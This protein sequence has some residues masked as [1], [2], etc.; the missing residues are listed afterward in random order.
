MCNTVSVENKTKLT[1]EEQIMLAKK[2]G[3]LP[4]KMTIRS[5]QEKEEMKKK[6]AALYTMM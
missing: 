4:T 6:L 1:T 2:L 3:I 5:E